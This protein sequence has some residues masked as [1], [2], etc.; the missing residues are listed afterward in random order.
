MVEV[1]L[2]KD[3]LIIHLKGID[4]FLALKS[5][6]TLPLDH[7]ISA[8]VN[9]E[10][11]AQKLLDESIRLPGAYMPGI[12]IAGR[13]YHHGK[14]LFWDIHKGQHAITIQTE[15][16]KYSSIVIEVS[17]PEAT[18]DAIKKAIADRKAG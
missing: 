18:V 15:H 1:E 6:L 11:E 17:D 14:Y 4:L 5:E 12:A 13:F 7:I 16:E 9:I 10:P 2:T 8:S 3:A